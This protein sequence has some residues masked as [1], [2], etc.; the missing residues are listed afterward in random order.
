MN[1][2]IGFV[3]GWIFAIFGLLCVVR[4]YCLLIKKKQKTDWKELGIAI[5]AIGIIAIA[6][7]AWMLCKQ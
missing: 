4:F 1:A 6:F 5:I 7:S 2:T 3:V